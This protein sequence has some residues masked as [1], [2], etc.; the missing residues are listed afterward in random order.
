VGTLL[1]VLYLCTGHLVAWQRGHREIAIVTVASAVAMSLVLFVTTHNLIPFNISLLCAAA[2]SEFAACRGRWLGQR[3]MAALVVDFAIITKA[4]IFS[5]STLPEGYAPLAQSSVLAIQLT[6]VLLYLLSTAY[7]TFAAHTV[8]SVFE[9][10]QNVVAIGLLILGQFIMAPAS[11]QHRLAGVISAI[12][13]LACYTAS[14]LP[15]HTKAQRNSLAFS[16]FGLSLLVAA[17]TVLFPT[18]NRVFA[19]YVLGVGAA[20][21]GN[22]QHQMS[23]Q[24]HAPVYLFGA[25]L[26]SDLIQIPNQSLTRLVVP[27][28]DHLTAMLISTAAIGLAYTFVGSGPAAKTRIPALFCAALLV[29]S[30]VGLGAIAIKA[31][32]G[33]LLFATSLRIG[34]ICLAAIGSAHW[35]MLSRSHA[36]RPEWVWLSFP[37]MLYGALRI[38]VEDLPSGRPA[39]TALSLL[40]YGGTLLL[41]TRILRPRIRPEPR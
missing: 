29:W 21:L 3:W 36:D 30:V 33:D 5:Q 11:G 19:W 17:V 14:I 41:L 18:G 1:I 6:L 10:A 23:M 4:W 37:L 38:M 24:W 26:G 9:L 32:C 15:S 34:L 39:A 20:C 31:I 7:R 22:R 12:L 16:I 2:A 40:L 28:A 8:I 25:V 13:A 27:R 35:G